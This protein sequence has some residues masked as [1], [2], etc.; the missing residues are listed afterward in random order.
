M[1]AK[2]ETLPGVLTGTETYL[3]SNNDR[4]SKKEKI[5]FN[6]CSNQ[7][8]CWE[9]NGCLVVVDNTSHYC[10]F[11]ASSKMGFSWN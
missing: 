1:S 3:L 7:K 10:S 2:L 5:G 8:P 11:A 4:L 6:E 9:P